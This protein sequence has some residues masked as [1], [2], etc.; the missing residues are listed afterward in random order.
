[1]VSILGTFIPGIPPSLSEVPHYYNVRPGQRKRARRLRPR[2]RSGGQ[3]ENPP[4]KCRRAFVPVA[5]KPL[6]GLRGLALGEHEV[7]HVPP[8]LDVEHV[9][10]FPLAKHYISDSHSG[11]QGDDAQNGNDQYFDARPNNLP[12]NSPRRALLPGR[13]TVGS[14]QRAPPSRC[15]PRR[16]VAICIIWSPDARALAFS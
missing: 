2:S 15:Y 8:R 1:M 7:V 4:R 5:F 3:K 12:Q 13:R 10:Q 6:C 11:D 16:S 14:R 9:G